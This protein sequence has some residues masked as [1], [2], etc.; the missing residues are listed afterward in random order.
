MKLPN[1][2]TGNACRQQGNQNTR[3]QHV[4]DVAGDELVLA[5]I[6]QALKQP[7]IMPIVEKFANDVMK[8]VSTPCMWR[9][10]WPMMSCTLSMTTNS[11]VTSF[12]PMYCASWK[13]S[14]L[15]RPSSQANGNMMQP[16]MFSSVMAG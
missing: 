4:A 3:Q 16:R 7:M 14:P 12:V 6:D 8:T 11:F 9:L 10:N 13:A 15:S 5:V 2:Q 1:E